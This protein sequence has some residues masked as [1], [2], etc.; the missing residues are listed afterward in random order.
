MALDT[1]TISMLSDYV[2]YERPPDN[3]TLWSA[4]PRGMF[5][6]YTRNTQLDAKALN[7]EMLLSLTGTLPPN[8]A[9]VMAYANFSIAQ[10]EAIDWINR[11]NL[12]LQSFYRL[13]RFGDAF[14]LAGNYVQEFPINDVIDTG[15]AI[16]V[17]N[18]WPTFPIM[19]P[20]TA[21]GILLNFSTGNA[22]TQA[23]TAGVVDAFLG[24]WQFDLEQI[25]KFTI[26]SPLPVQL[27]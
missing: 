25:R 26:N 10:D 16:S 21:S 3:V 13:N 19:A 27:R 15:R 12:N 17:I 9:Y 24:F 14:A 6:F 1:Q 20:P 18:P 22:G 23:T 4:I 2:P 11:V 5:T 8:F 7:D